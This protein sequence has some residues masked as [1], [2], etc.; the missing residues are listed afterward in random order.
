MKETK[1]NLS[2]TVLSIFLALSPVLIYLSGSLY[3]TFLLQTVQ[4]QVQTIPVYPKAELVE[5]TFSN[6]YALADT[7]RDWS[8]RYKYKAEDQREAI[9][10]YYRNTLPRLGWAYKQTEG[11]YAMD[12]YSRDKFQ[13]WIPHFYQEDS[14]NNDPAVVI[15][16]VRYRYD[17]RFDL[18]R[19]EPYEP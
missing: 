3:N 18:L 11:E 1:H 2:V 8:W 7:R 16:Y 5:I 17:V 14:K 19:F 15:V 10:N 12:I 9:L 4:R 6:E 13:L